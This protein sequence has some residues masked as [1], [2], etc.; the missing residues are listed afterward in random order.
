MV[1]DV[2]ELLKDKSLKYEEILKY[3]K[4]SDEELN[5]ILKKDDTILKNKLDTLVKEGTIIL[6]KKN[7][8]MLVSNTNYL[9]GKIKVKDNTG[10]IYYNGNEILIKEYNLNTATDKDIVLFTYDI[11]TMEG[12]VVS[13]LEKNIPVVVCEVTLNDNERYIK[14]NNK[15]LPL[16]G[17]NTSTITTG[18]LV[19]AEIKSNKAYLKEKIGHKDEITD[20][21]IPLMYKHGFNNKF[22]NEVENEAKKLYKYLDKDVIES[23]IKNE[24]FLDLRDKTIFTIDSET[25]NDIDDAVSLERNNDGTFT[26]ITSIAFPAYMI[27]KDSYIYEDIIERGTSA[28]PVSTAIHMNHQ[29][30]SKDVCSLNENSDR[31][32]I[33]YFIT[34]DNNLNVKEVQIKPS[35]I[36][37]KKK[38]TYTCVNKILNEGIIPED[39]TEFVPMLKQMNYFAK[40]LKRKME[41]EGFIDFDSYEIKVEKEGNTTNFAKN[42]NSDG[43]NLI[44][45]LMLTTNEEVT[46]KLDSLGLKLMYRVCDKPNDIKLNKTMHFL[47]NKID[48]KEKEHYGSSDIKRCIKLL[49]N[50]ENKK[51]Y[52]DLM[53]RCMSLARFSSKNTGHYPVGKKIYAMHTS[54]MRRGED[55]INQMIILNYL[56]HGVEYANMLFNLELEPLAEH[57]NEREKEAE[58]LERESLKL[59]ISKYLQNH[60][61][62]SHDGVITSV[63]DFGFYVLID[64]IYEGLVN[65][66]SLNAKTKYLDEEFTLYDKT[67][68]IYY[69]VGDKVN[70]TISNI[71]QNNEID[72]TLNNKIKNDIYEEKKKIK[73]K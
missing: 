3:I 23:L 58:L 67:N 52:N 27:E 42:I 16:V 14:Y 46:K 50:D 45:F 35:I 12:Q 20:D 32:S 60:I 24:G 7:K 73:K 13:I 53:I 1:L 51:V 62:E 39:Y 17:E 47:Q 34:Y 59:E 29:I 19:V 15:Y 70:V 48:I 6:T 10:K 69:T 44:E 22:S 36:R 28:Y 43:E 41:K 49:K 65:A 31:L 9:K 71:T 63:T 64:G 68:N 18:F 26:L 72:L 5:K 38:M 2:V 11:D 21:I 54:P 57:F 66:H 8:Y 33:S 4:N 55:F 25:T 56:K 37:S 40:A 61:G 30:L